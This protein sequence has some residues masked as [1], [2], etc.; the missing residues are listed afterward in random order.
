MDRSQLAADIFNRRALL[1]QQKYM[2]V[3]NYSEA[4]D[5]F[6]EA[7]KIKD[8]KVLELACG[9]GNITKYL[10]DK[11]SDFKILGLDL[12][13]VMID[14]AKENN[15]AA[16]FRVMDC[17]QI[18]AFDEKYEGVVC[19]FGLP[20]LTM[21]EAAKLVKDVYELLIPGGVFYLSTMEAD[22]SG[23]QLVTSPT[24]GDQIHI[25]YYKGSDLLRILEENRFDLLSM[26]R[27]LIG[28]DT[29]LMILA[30]K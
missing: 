15:P 30:Q 4:L 29:D 24:T 22:E 21:E 8:A 18:S 17:R 12:A 28:A 2:D 16:H 3:S 6:C 13:P 19:G 26:D 10:L 27:K 1:Y 5:S 20:Y 7:V 25:H 14:L 11:R 23:S 9:P